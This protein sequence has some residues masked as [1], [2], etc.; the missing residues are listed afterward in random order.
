MSRVPSGRVI[1]TVCVPRR[2]RTQATTAPAQAAATPPG[3]STASTASPAAPMVPGASPSVCLRILP[4][5]SGCPPSQRLKSSVPAGP[6]T[7]STVMVTCM[8]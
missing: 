8:L 5:K 6:F 4:R 1:V 2:V 3:S 7:L